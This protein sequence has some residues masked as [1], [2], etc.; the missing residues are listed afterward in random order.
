MPRSLLSERTVARWFR[1]RHPSSAGEREVRLARNLW[2]AVDAPSR[3]EFEEICGDHIVEEQRRVL[4]LVGTVLERHGQHDLWQTI[5]H[6]V[7]ECP[8]DGEETTFL[9]TMTAA[10]RRGEV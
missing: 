4:L 7:E 5:Y 2:P 1:G 6:S 8:R 3:V 9:T 10:A